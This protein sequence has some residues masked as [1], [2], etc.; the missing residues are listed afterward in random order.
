[1]RASQ[2]G[3]GLGNGDGKRLGVNLEQQ[4]ALIHKLV[5]NHRHLD[6]RP[7][8]PG[9]DLDHL[10]A[11]LSVAGPGVVD[12]LLEGLVGVPEHCRYQHD[13]DNA[14]AKFLEKFHP[15]IPL[16]FYPEGIHQDHV[17][18]HQCQKSK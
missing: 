7:G 5:V 1:M 2:I 17:K 15:L 16:N 12:V 18:G 10:P 9:S 14:Q 8:Y 4:I 13:I 11:Q 3:L 6:D